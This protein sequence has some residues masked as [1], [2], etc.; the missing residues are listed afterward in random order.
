M[1]SAWEL[2][3]QA[4]RLMS[5]IAD[6]GGVLTDETEEALAAW[7]N[8]SEDKVGACIHAARRLEQE[9]SLL[10]EE[11][12]RLASRRR[13]LAA[14]EDRV[15]GYATSMLLEMETMGMEPK[16]RAPSYSVW[17]GESES[18]HAP[19]DQSL[20]PEEFIRVSK[21]VDKRGLTEAVRQGAALP[22]GFELVKK[23]SVR[24]R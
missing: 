17:L 7:V 23:R 3:E 12:E 6:D 22:Q 2:V 16:L 24:F 15:R 20:W 5:V 1:P 9:Q 4:R 18:L 8:A 21:S 13:A 10:K 11:E 19:D 14:A